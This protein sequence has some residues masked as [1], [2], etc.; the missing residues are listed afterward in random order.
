MSKLAGLKKRLLVTMSK[1]TFHSNTTNAGWLS[2]ELAEVGIESGAMP[3]GPVCCANHCP[4]SPFPSLPY[5]VLHY[6]LPGCDHIYRPELVAACAAANPD[7][8]FV[9]VGNPSLESSGRNVKVL[10]SIAADAM[11]S[12]YARSHC[13][14]RVTTHDGLPRMVLEALAHGLDVVTNLPVPHTTPAHTEQDVVAALRK[15]MQTGVAR[16]LEARKWY[17]ET[18][19]ASAW[20]R[21]W[22]TQLI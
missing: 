19:S 22:Q 3:F 9:C 12:L 14:L 11:R 16:N 6:S 17:F 8:A 1:R 21:Y 10:G 5:T 18:Y 20:A 15:L 13:L 2:R 7:I 4:L